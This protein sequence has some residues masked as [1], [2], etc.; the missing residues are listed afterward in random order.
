MNYI[1]KY[2]YFQIRDIWLISE[3]IHDN[4]CKTLVQ[5]IMIYRLDY[6]NA[7]L[8]NTPLS[9]KP[10]RPSVELCCTS[11]YTQSQKRTHNTYCFGQFPRVPVLFRP[12]YKILFHTFKVLS[13]TAPLYLS[14]LIQMYIPVKIMRSGSSW[15]L[16]EQKSH[17]IINSGCGTSC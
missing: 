14:D 16:A 3:Y 4:T 11:G 2:R 17:R 12:L 1:C 13:R 8:Y 10:P 6:G 15:L 5:S 7:L 9:D